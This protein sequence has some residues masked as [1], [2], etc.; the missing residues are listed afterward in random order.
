MHNFVEC[1]FC[2]EKYKNDAIYYRGITVL[3]VISKIVKAVIRDRIQRLIHNMQNPTFY[4]AFRIVV[5]AF[6][7]SPRFVLNSRVVHTPEQM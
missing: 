4:A 3:P 7:N 1:S 6:N 5:Q 2:I